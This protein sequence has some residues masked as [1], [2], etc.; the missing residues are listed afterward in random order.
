MLPW[1]RIECKFLSQNLWICHSRS[2]YS[3]EHK[4]LHQWFFELIQNIYKTCND[5]HKVNLCHMHLILLALTLLQHIHKIL[6]ANH[7]VYQPRLRAKEFYHETILAPSL[8]R[9]VWI[10]TFKILIMLQNR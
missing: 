1:L 4:V 9:N 2:F 10:S 6:T 7:D 8:R 5:I 3:K